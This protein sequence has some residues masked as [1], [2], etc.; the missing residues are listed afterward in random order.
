MVRGFPKAK[1]DSDFL[2]EM[3]R[4]G[5]SPERQPQI[6]RLRSPQRPSL[7]MT[8]RFL[9]QEFEVRRFLERFDLLNP[10]SGR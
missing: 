9:M 3:R 6:P 5:K 7:G 8:H 10:E 1:T 2:K 4:R